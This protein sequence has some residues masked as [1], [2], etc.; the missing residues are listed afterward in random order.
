MSSRL[1]FTVDLPQLQALV[2][3]LEMLHSLN[4]ITFPGSKSVKQTR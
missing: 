4:D 3:E 2:Y 1:V